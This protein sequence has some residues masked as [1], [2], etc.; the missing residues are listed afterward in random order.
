MAPQ[1]RLRRALHLLLVAALLLPSGAWTARALAATDAAAL[2]TMP[3]HDGMAAAEPPAA[4]APCDEGCCP[5]PDCDLSACLAT[6]CLP[7]LVGVSGVRP[8]LPLAFPWRLDAPPSQP[9]DALLR[10]PIA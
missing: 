5:Q 3:C 7:R 8:P 2:A 1:S 6:A 4:G 9:I 10:P